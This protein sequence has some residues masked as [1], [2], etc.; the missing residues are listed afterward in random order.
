MKR[1]FHWAGKPLDL[2]DDAFVFKFFPRLPVAFVY[3]RGDEEFPPYSKILYDVSASNYM[4]THGLRALTE[5][6]VQHL[7]GEE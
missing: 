2:G 3:W 4:S 6:L 7:I 5:F 1:V